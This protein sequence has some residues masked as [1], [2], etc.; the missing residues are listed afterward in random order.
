MQ[1][2]TPP[3]KSFNASGGERIS[4]QKMPRRLN[5]FCAAR[6]NSVVGRLPCG[7]DEHWQKRSDAMHILEHVFP[8]RDDG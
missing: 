6:V 3:N 4:H 2:V 5:E 8:G 7:G 1:T